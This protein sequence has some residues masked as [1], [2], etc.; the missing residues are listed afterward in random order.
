[1]DDHHEANVPLLVI[2]QELFDALPV[3]QFELNNQNIWCERLVDVNYAD[4]SSS[5]AKGDDSSLAGESKEELRHHLRFV[6]SPGPTPASKVLLKPEFHVKPTET[7]PEK[8]LQDCKPGD[9]IEVSAVSA[10]LTQSI[11][12][13]LTFEGGAALIIDYGDNFVSQDSLRG[14]KEH[15][16]VHPLQEPGEIDLSADVNFSLLKRMALHQYNPNELLRKGKQVYIIN[17]FFNK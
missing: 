2:A 9:C 1:V 8:T 5:N 17:K 11:S 7:E 10:A 14:I 15:A 16:F 6:L 12:K 4:S 13:R 3:H